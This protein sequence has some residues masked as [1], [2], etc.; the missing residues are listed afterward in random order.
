MIVTLHT[1]GLQTLAQVRAFVSGSQP[2]SFTLEDR[3]CF[4]D[5]M[6]CTLRQF[7]YLRCKC[8]DKC[9]LWRY[10]RK[11]TGLSRAQVARC[12]KQFTTDRGAIRMRTSVCCWLRW[13]HCMGASK[14]LS[15]ANRTLLFASCQ[16]IL[17]TRTPIC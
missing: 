3:T 12:I 14:T 1:Q 16:H 5:W 11:V 17:D 4:Y 9:I 13:M 2:H 10:L 6:A 8:S 15:R 7:G